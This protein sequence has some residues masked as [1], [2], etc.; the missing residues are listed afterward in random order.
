MN[1]KKIN[2][3]VPSLRTIKHA[4]IFTNINL[5]PTFVFF[6]KDVLSI[7]QVF[8]NIHYSLLHVTSC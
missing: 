5:Q 6:Q 3:L 2:L 7:A 1:Y 4:T 8:R